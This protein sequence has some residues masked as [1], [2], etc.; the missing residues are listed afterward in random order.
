M[1]QALRS[2]TQSRR[3]ASE[4]GTLS[5]LE[6]KVMSSFF[7]KQPQHQLQRCVLDAWCYCTENFSLILPKPCTLPVGGGGGGSYSYSIAQMRKLKNRE[8]K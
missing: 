7:T 2:G 3:E 6:D 4:A 8:V 1:N 5:P